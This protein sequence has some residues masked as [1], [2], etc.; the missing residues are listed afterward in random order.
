MSGEALRL[1]GAHFM[2]ELKILKNNWN[3]VFLVTHQLNCEKASAS[4]ARKPVWQDAAEWKGFAL[5]MDVC[6]AIGSLSEEQVCWFCA[7]KVRSTAASDRMVK[8]RGDYIKFV[9]ADN[10]YM[11]AHGK[12]VPKVNAMDDM[13]EH[14]VKTRRLDTGAAAQFE[15]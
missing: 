13:Q 8:L 11:M 4:S 2:D 12:I 14:P 10:E 15:G 5:F 3:V 6:F 1:F 9:E 7:S